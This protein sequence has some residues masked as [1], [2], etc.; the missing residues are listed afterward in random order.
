MLGSVATVD[1]QPSP[2]HQEVAGVGG[3]HAGPGGGEGGQAG[4]VPG[5]QALAHGPGG[6]QEEG[7]GP[8]GDGG[9]HATVH[10]ILILSTIGPITEYSIK[11]EVSDRTKRENLIFNRTFG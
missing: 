8:G 9:E 1:G 11:Y 7:G 5:V 3:G 2:G 6:Q 4:L 10:R